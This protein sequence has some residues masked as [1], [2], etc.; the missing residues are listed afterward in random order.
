LR[1]I[2]WK[3][4][5]RSWREAMGAAAMEVGGLRKKRRGGN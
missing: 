5:A 4:L 1:R 3:K 2:D